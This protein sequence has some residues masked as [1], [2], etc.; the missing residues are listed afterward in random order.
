VTAAAAH[1]AAHITRQGHAWIASGRRARRYRPHLFLEDLL[2]LRRLFLGEFGRPRWAITC[3][4]SMGGHIVVA[5]LEQY[6]GPDQE[7][8]WRIINERVVPALGTP[9]EYTERRRQFDSVVKYL[10]GATAAS[11]TRRASA[12][13]TIS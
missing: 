12:R 11:G 13:S 5:T 8:F 9:G 10:M 7:T 2:A 1:R 4:Q 6:P 3:G